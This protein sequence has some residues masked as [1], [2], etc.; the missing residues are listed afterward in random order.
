MIINK[1]LRDVTKEEFE[2]WRNNT[3]SGIFCKDCMFKSVICS[4]SP[5]WVNN[6]EI[7]SDKFLNKEIEIE[8]PDILDKEEKEYLSAVIKPFRNRVTNITKLATCESFEYIFIYVK[9]ME[10]FSLPSFKSNTM[11]KGMK[12][13]KEYTLKDLGL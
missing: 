12:L 3:C 2:Q 6:K 5:S 7:F 13:N 10:G 11:Y 4:G 9:T 8:T 1:K